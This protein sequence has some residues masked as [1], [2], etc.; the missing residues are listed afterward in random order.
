MID[1]ETEISAPELNLF[2]IQGKKLNLVLAVIA[3]V[4]MV[5]YCF[6]ES[7]TAS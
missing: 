3:K 7:L 1:K 6:F 4:V 5:D 2:P